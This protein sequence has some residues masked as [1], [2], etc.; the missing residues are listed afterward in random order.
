LGVIAL[1]LH[2]ALGEVAAI[3]VVVIV[4]V[5]LQI[6]MMGISG[7][8]SLM[9]S[10]TGEYIKTITLLLMEYMVVGGFV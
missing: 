1:H 10:L 7:Q 3:V 2:Q 8:F 6:L 9:A 4:V 5:Q